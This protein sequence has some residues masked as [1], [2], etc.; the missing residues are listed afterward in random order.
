VRTSDHGKEAAPGL[1][2]AYYD[3]PASP[4]LQSPRQLA[5]DRVLDPEMIDL[6]I[7][8]GS[9]RGHRSI[10]GERNISRGCARLLGLHLNRPGGEPVLEKIEQAVESRVRHIHLWSVRSAI[11]S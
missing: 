2:Q 9:R 5:D 6:R 4:R 11:Q 1:E 8:F 10:G 3:L 7:R